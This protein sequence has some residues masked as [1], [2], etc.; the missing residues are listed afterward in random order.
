MPNA[1][2]VLLLV[3]VGLASVLFGCPPA[4]DGPDDGAGDSSGD[5]NTPPPAQGEWYQPG[6]DTTWQWQLQTDADGRINTTYDVDV[7]DIDLFDS[8]PEPIEELHAQGRRVICYFS[9]GTFE[10]FRPDADEFLAAELGNTLEDYVDERW[11]DIRSANVRRIMQARLD[12]AVQRGCDGV[13]PDNVDAY[14]NDS[15]FAL[16]PADQL[17]FNRFLANEAHARGL[18][19]GLKND[20][21]QVPELVAYF[22]FC[23][24][25]QCHEYDECDALQPFIDAG[26]PVFNA[27]YAAEFV[28]N[29][30]RRAALCEDARD[31]SFQTLV[32]PPDL[33]DAFRF[34]C[35]P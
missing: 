19:V 30:V 33:D 22:D 17:D 18:S 21:D 23:V 31:R 14:D 5:T 26:K 34:A 11:L 35:D 1:R 3:L 27:E 13:E 16:T 12:L 4:A 25:E 7:Y 9:A 32:L 20:V 10:D 15:G 2:S 24:N 29:A 6:V 28:N 8:S